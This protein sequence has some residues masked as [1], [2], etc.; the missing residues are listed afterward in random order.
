MPVDA[1]A[2]R[3]P[4]CREPLEVRGYARPA[5]R[6]GSWPSQTLVERYAEFLP[7]EG[8]RPGMS[9]GEGFTPLVDC[10][11]TL[12]HASESPDSC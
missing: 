7:S 4:A 6:H 3:C 1:A 2:L 12:L 10:P 5:I 9:L 11:Q 8:Y